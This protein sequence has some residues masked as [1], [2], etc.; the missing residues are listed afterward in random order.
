MRLNFAF[1]SKPCKLQYII[2]L[3]QQRFCKGPLGTPSGTFRSGR[4][5]RRLLAL[6]FILPRR[7]HSIL[8][9]P[10]KLH[11]Q[12]ALI[13]HGPPWGAHWF[14]CFFFNLAWAPPNTSQGPLGPPSEPLKNHWFLTLLPLG[15]PNRYRVSAIRTF[16]ALGPPEDPSKTFKNY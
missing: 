8:R 7:E 1:S 2:D 11:I 6:P 16:A 3:S 5:G 14:F 4:H 12:I 15:P 13:S 9:T 10:C